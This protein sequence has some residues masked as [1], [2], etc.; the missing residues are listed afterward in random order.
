[1]VEVAKILLEFIGVFLI[2]YIGYYFLSYRKIKK[3]DRKKMPVNVKYLVFKYKV[4]VVRLGYKRV[5]KTLMLCDS[6]IIATVFTVT[7]FVDN[8]YVRL[9]VAF[10]LIFPI[11]A[12]MYHLV[13]TY[14]KK[15]SEK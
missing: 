7:R 6:F 9:F 2:V 12:G 1:M 5:C 10:I 11:F 15:E 13:A 3:F 4:D 8:I 14:Y